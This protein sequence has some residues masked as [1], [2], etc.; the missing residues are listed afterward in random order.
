MADTA[1]AKTDLK[2]EEME[3]RLS[4]I[5]SRAGKEIQQTA[6]EYFSKF[7]KQDEAKRKLLVQGIHIVVRH[8]DRDKTGR[9]ILQNSA[10]CQLYKLCQHWL[11]RVLCSGQGGRSCGNEKRTD[12]LNRRIRHS[13]LYVTSQETIIKCKPCITGVQALKVL[14]YMHKEK[15]CS[16]THSLYTKLLFCECK[17]GNRKQRGILLWL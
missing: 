7:A 10:R 9:Q 2:L 14:I 3:K 8:G 4:A 12:N 6:D 13:D 17:T 1:H 11:H 16:A 15:G 5:Y